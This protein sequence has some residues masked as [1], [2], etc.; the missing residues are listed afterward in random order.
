MK[1]WENNFSDL[2]IK[3]LLEKMTVE[4]LIDE[5]SELTEII[6]KLKYDVN[7]H[8][9]PYIERGEYNS[10]DWNSIHKYCMFSDDKYIKL[11]QFLININYPI[12][13]KELRDKLQL[14]EN[15]FNLL[16]QFVNT[17]YNSFIKKSFI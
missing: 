16:E 12:K 6:K 8:F 11:K 4:E 7:N 17:K 1:F 3:N 9:S 2:E 10:L 13:L 14:Y 5:I 15:Y